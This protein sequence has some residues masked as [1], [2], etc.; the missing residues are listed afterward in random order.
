MHFDTTATKDPLNSKTFKERFKIIWFYGFLYS[1]KV[2][3]WCIIYDKCYG[4]K[5]QYRVLIALT[6]QVKLV[7]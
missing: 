1:F 2:I 4:T 6:E 7:L 5:R 3:V